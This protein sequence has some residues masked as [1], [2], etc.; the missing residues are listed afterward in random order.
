M[1]AQKEAKKL[2]PPDVYRILGLFSHLLSAR[3]NLWE[4]IAAI[5]DPRIEIMCT[6]TM[7]DI[8]ISALLMHFFKTGSRNNYNEMRKVDRFRRQIFLWLNVKLP[9]GDTIHDVIKAIDP[10]Y[11]NNIL[12]Y[13]GAIL[14]RGNVFAKDKSFGTFKIILDGSSIGTLTESSVWASVQES[15]NGVVSM[16]RSFVLAT[17][18]GPSGL[19]IPIMWEPIAQQDGHLKQD[20]EQNAAARLLARLKSK[21]PRTCFTIILDALYCTEPKMRTIHELGWKFVVVFKEGSQPNLWEQFINRLIN[22]TTDDNIL[23]DDIE[24]PSGKKPGNT[25]FRK[26]SWVNDLQGLCFPLAAISCR[27]SNVDWMVDCP[28]EDID[29]KNFVTMT[30]FRINKDNA[31]HIEVIGRDRWNVEESFNHSKNRGARI[32]HKFSRRSQV[33]SEIY[34]T[35][36]YMA[37]VFELLITASIWFI[38]NFLGQHRTIKSAWTEMLASLSQREVDTEFIA[39]VQVPKQLQYIRQLT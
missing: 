5:P 10:T 39:Q 26:I 13:M 33:A 2:C 30:N 16:H 31:K 25:I 6:Y 20:C 8:V 9:H 15:K 37:E 3:F 32:K 27:E 17:L 18:V 11:F 23:D 21:F 35:I 1:M 7:A 36:I 12:A 29:E 28:K 38:K 19:R 24:V 34:L 22:C 14:L 4:K